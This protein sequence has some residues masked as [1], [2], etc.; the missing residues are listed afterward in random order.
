MITR[1]IAK[2][3][4]ISAWIL[5]VGMILYFISG[6]GMTK[7]FIDPALATK[8][9]LSYL[10][11]VV[12]VG[13]ILHTYYAIH[14][15]FKR[16]RVWNGYTKL[17]LLLFYLF[18]FSGFIYVDRFYSAEK[19]T[20]EDQ[21]ENAPAVSGSQSSSASSSTNGAASST[22]TIQPTASSTAANTFTSAQLAKYDGTNGQP[23]YVAVDGSVYDLTSIFQQGRHFSHFA[24]TEL[25]NAFYSYHAKRVLAKYPIVGTLSQ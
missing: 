21:S 23:A 8:L 9:H 15:A 25:T 16:W 19:A 11:Y 18:F 12:M 10:T 24:G 4:R 17:L 2:I 14:L 3:D 20:A 13:F 7:G 1:I 6:Y 22:T 5:F